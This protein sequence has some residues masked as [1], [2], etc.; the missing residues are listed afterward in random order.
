MKSE[1][2]D[3]GHV[4]KVSSQRA[5]P[6]R[7]RIELRSQTKV[8]KLPTDITK[9]LLLGSSFCVVFK[10]GSLNVGGLAHPPLA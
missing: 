9:G 2:I 7:R 8:V 5:V 10:S 3:H 1:V 6:I 4:F